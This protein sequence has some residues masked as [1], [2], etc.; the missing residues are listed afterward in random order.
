VNNQLLLDGRAVGSDNNYL[1]TSSHKQ[2]PDKS[3][4]AGNSNGDEH[5]FSG[6]IHPGI[7]TVAVENVIVVLD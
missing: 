6:E 1:L 5:S 2:D 4:Y 3:I 7:Q